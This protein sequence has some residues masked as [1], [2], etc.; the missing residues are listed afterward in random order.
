MDE[1]LFFNGISLV[2][3]CLGLV[4]LTKALGVKGN[5]LIL[6]STLLGA[7]LAVG[8]KIAASGV[9]VDFAG[10]FS[11]IILGLVAGLSASGVYKVANKDRV[12]VTR[13]SPSGNVSVTEE[14]VQ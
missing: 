14:K 11:L 4:E 1:S 2:T 9:P 7:L 5:W 13:I 3:L 10:W 12:S 6:E 8:G